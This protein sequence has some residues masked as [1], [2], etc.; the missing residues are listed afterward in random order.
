MSIHAPIKR[1]VFT[2]LA[3]CSVLALAQAGTGAE[4]ESDSCVCLGGLEAGDRVIS[5]HELQSGPGAGRVGSVVGG[6]TFEFAGNTVRYALVMFDDW[7]EGHGGS[8]WESC[9]GN[10]QSDQC[11]WVQCGWLRELPNSAPPCD[12]DLNK[13]GIVDGAD[14]LNLLDNWGFCPL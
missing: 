11:W 14:L 3:S 6:F 10:I 1:F 9:L 7:H 2:V 13:D 12:G 4:E 8:G 5:T